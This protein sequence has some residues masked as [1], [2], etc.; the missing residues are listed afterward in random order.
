[1]CYISHVP[2]ISRSSCSRYIVGHL[3]SVTW[4]PASLPPVTIKD[5]IRGLA[6][7]LR[8]R[9]LTV[10]QEFS[11]NLAEVLVQVC[12]IGSV[13]RIRSCRRMI[14]PRRHIY[15]MVEGRVIFMHTYIRPSF[16]P[17]SYICLCVCARVCLLFMKYILVWTKW[18]PERLRYIYIMYAVITDVRTAVDRA[19]STGDRPEPASRSRD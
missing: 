12:T 16:S 6:A 18:L 15:M 9:P 13:Q 2:T 1:M 10:S 17:F 3:Y 5:L 4:S 8:H 7:E 14:R 19:L 11:C